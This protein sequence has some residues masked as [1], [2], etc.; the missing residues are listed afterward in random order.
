MARFLLDFVLG[1]VSFSAL[2]LQEDKPVW[3]VFKADGLPNQLVSNPM[4]ASVNEVNFAVR[5]ILELPNLSGAYLYISLCCHDDVGRQVRR[6][7][8]A[9]LGLKAFPVGNPKQFSFP[10]M[11]ASNTAVVIAR[12]TFTACISA[13]VPFVSEPVRADLRPSVFEPP[14]PY[15]SVPRSPYNSM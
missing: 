14:G 8:F 6:M 9:K 5:L 2:S 12:V 1:K 11:D 13:F 10:V 3:F 15:S 7:G 4:P